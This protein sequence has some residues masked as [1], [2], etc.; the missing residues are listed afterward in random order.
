VGHEDL[1][2]WG[3][4]RSLYFE[5]VETWIGGLGK[6]QGSRRGQIELGPR[7]VATRME[8]D[9]YETVMREKSST[10]IA[11]LRTS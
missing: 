5:D 4:C 6:N 7:K 11:R 3:T 10:D 2:M 1:V 9:E 8:G